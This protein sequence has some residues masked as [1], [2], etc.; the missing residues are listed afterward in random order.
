MALT[1]SVLVSARVISMQEP[2]FTWAGHL[3]LDCTL[4]GLSMKWTET[5]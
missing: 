1:L 2:L 3:I 4:L 5:S